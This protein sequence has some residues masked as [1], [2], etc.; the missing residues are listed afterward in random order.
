MTVFVNLHKL[1]SNILEELIRNK[2]SIWVTKGLMLPVIFD[3]NY[4]F[5]GGITVVCTLLWVHVQMVSRNSHY[6]IKRG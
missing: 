4:T 3:D 5:K 6:A 2:I 1:M